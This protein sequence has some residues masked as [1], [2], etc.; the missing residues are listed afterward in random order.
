ML[1]AQE[2][3]AEAAEHFLI[4]LSQDKSQ[5][6]AWEALLVCESKSA[7]DSPQLMEH[8]REAAELFPLHLRPYLVLAQCYLS[9]G[10]CKMAKQY[11]G[12]ALMVSP[13]DAATNELNYKIKQQCQNAD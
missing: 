13:N 10:D 12:R 8:A 5:Y 6:A 1:A 2:R 3:Y 11:I 9:Q 7:P 4:H